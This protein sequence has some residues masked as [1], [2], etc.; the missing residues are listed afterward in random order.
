MK[1]HSSKSGFTLIELLVVVA[2]IGFMSSVVLASLASARLRA[3]D[4]TIRS[5][6][7]QFASLAELEYLDNKSYANFQRGWIYTPAECAGYAGNYAARAEAICRELVGKSGS[8][9][10]GNYP[11]HSGTQNV[12]YTKEYSLM[13]Y[14]PYKQVYACTGS[15]GKSDTTTGAN[16]WTEPGCYMNP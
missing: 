5:N 16:M 15:S 11:F 3:R 6:L 7:Q 2:I 14:M 10:V 1:F 8:G 9:F 12:L 4:S 13:V